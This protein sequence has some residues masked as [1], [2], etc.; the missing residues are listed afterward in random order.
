QYMIPGDNGKVISN[1]DMQGGNGGGGTVVQQE[2]NFHITTTNGIDDATMS[3]MA[4]MMKQVAIF[5]MK[6]QSS[7][8]G[9][10]LQPRKVR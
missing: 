3:K 4:T 6:D 10:F 7:R 2:V 5:Q 9:G 8:P 1:K